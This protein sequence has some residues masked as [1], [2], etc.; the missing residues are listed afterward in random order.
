MAE[1]EEPVEMEPVYQRFHELNKAADDAFKAYTAASLVDI[2]P[3]E[4]REAHEEATIAF[5]RYIDNNA[6]ALMNA[7]VRLLKE[8][9]KLIEQETQ[10]MQLPEVNVEEIERQERE[11]KKGDEG[12]S[13]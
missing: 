8:R 11:R 6:P 10:R 13:Q 1:Q 7:H 4:A 5:H 2:E 3:T 12:M 9:N